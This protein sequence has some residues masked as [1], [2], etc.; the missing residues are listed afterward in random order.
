MISKQQKPT[1]SGFH[2]KTNADEITKEIDLSGKL[3]I[4]TGGYSGIGL[5]TTRA[6]VHAGAQ[7]IIPAKRIEIATKN[8]DGIVSK[9]NIEKETVHFL[10]PKQKITGIMNTNGQ[11]SYN[12]FI[13]YAY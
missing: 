1:Q 4:V 9:E 3:A 5:E 2:A 10:K 12:V 11:G 13:F 8:L 6:L 7:V